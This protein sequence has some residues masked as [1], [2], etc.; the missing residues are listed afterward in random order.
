ML[1]RNPTQ[2]LRKAIHGMLMGRQKKLLHG[3][4]EP[5][6]K[7]YTGEKHPHTAQ[8]PPN[9]DPLPAVPK[10]L[11]GDFHFGLEYYAHP[12]SYQPGVPKAGS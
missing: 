9:V 1:E 12:N 3:Y 8:L 6:L 5:R 7:I 2:I 11:R 10:T 4:I